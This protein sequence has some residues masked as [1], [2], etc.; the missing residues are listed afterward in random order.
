MQ[1]PTK[2]LFFHLGLSEVPEKSPRLPPPPH[3][4]RV[5]D[6][7]NNYTDPEKG[8][9]RSYSKHITLLKKHVRPQQGT[10]NN[11]TKI[12]GLRYFSI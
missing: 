1:F 11:D 8:N 5:V 3:T 2:F 4:G 6:H 7:Y 9:E 12:Y 10:E